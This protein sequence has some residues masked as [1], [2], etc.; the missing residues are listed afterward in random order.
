[1]SKLTLF[2]IASSARVGVLSEQLAKH[3]KQLTSWRLL[4]IA[5]GVWVAFDRCFSGLTPRTGREICG[6]V[7]SFRARDK[8]LLRLGPVPRPH[9]ISNNRK[10]Q[11]VLA[12]VF[13][14]IAETCPMAL[15][16]PLIP[17]RALCGKPPHN[18][19]TTI[20]LTSNPCRRTLLF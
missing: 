16:A 11:T 8:T 20:M 9:V 3:L 1:M 10:R 2:R 5:S 14:L 15:R 7:Q 4:L 12:H 19:L 18:A 17:V 6:F 13:T